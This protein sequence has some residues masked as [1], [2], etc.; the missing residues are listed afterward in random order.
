MNTVDFTALD[1]ATREIRPP[2]AVLDLRALHHNAESMRRRAGGKP[3]RVASKSVRCRALLERVLARDGFTGVMSFSLAESLW[4][5][6]SGVED[7]LLAYPTADRAGLAEL[8]AD[9]KLAR[10]VTV[11]VDDPAQLALID[12]ARTGRE[13][14]RVCLELDT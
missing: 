12:A 8:T 7:V 14:V 1:R 5:A 2:F 4:L 13:E 3:I 11:T 10:A 9:P 6:R